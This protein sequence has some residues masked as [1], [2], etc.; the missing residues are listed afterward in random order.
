MASR[1]LHLVDGR[2]SG[3]ALLVTGAVLWLGQ[4]VRFLE[5]Q[6]SDAEPCISS[7]VD[8]SILHPAARTRCSFLVP[9]Q[10]TFALLTTSR[11]RSSAAC[12]FRQMM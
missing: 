3:Q 4:R 7:T 10:A 1:T 8:A 5:Q 6:P 2:G 11:R 9:H 12:L